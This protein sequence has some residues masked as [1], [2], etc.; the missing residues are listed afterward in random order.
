MLIG[1]KLDIGFAQD[2]GYQRLYGGREILPFLRELGVELAETPIGPQTQPEA[3]REHIARCIDAGLQVT[4]HPYSEG[5]VF[6]PAHFRDS[7]DNPCRLF[8]ERFFSH[9]AE[10]AQ[11]QQSPTL[12]NIHGAAG[13]SADAR[14][15]L[16]ERSIAF[17]AWARNWCLQNA[18]EV[19]VTVE[20]QIRPNPDEPIQRIGD[21]YDELLEISTQSDVRICWDFGHAYWNARN[22]GCPIE[23]PPAVLG[24][25]GHVHCH[26]VNEGDHQPLVDTTVPWR[27]FLQ[28]LIDHGFDERIILEVP[29][30]AFLDAGGIGTLTT[31]V[32]ALRARLQELMIDY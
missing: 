21:R 30:D 8:H 14:P 13:A 23:P 19:S 3:L 29:T 9:A 32:Q 1:L 27:D 17:F 15:D 26:D 25:V 10:I 31:S 4:L 22:F 11:R 5:S 16:V 6:N 20:L 7:G 12:V 18:P 2:E 24:R 28:L